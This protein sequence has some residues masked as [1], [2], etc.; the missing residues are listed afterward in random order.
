MSMNAISSINWESTQKLYKAAATG[1]RDT[2]SKMTG[3][4][5]SSAKSISDAA[6]AGSVGAVSSTEETATDST[7]ASAQETTASQLDQNG[8]GSVQKTDFQVDV[9]ALKK[10]HT[11]QT[12]QFYASMMAG[13]LGSVGDSS[14]AFA[15]F[16]QI[17]DSVNQ[18]VGMSSILKNMSQDQLQAAAQSILNTSV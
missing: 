5:F 12:N 9:D 17:M 1:D 8:K 7:T 15:D 13:A 2:V 4:D 18:S 3:I 6:K 14:T 16:A 11:A 10:A